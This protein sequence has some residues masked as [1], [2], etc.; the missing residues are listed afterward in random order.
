M[1][2]PIFGSTPIWFAW[3]P[4]DFEKIQVMG[5]PAR[6]VMKKEIREAMKNALGGWQLILEL[7]CFKQEEARWNTL[8]GTW[9]TP[10]FRLAQ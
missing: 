9:N 4:L 5:S 6:K 3:D 8:V 2:H 1:I 10:A 7:P